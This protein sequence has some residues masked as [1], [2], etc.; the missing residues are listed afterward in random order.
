M[1]LDAK[2]QAVRAIMAS[3]GVRHYQMTMRMPIVLTT[4]GVSSAP[5]SFANL[6]SFS[7]TTEAGELLMFSRNASL[8]EALDAAVEVVKTL[9]EDQVVQFWLNEELQGRYYTL[10]SLVTSETAPHAV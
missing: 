10:R 5:I 6:V 2:L 9:T 7:A 1:Q 8:E 4:N 3:Y